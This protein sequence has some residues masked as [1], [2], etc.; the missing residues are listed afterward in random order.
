MWGGRND[1]RCW[2]A[3]QNRCALS[4]HVGPLDPQCRPA[5]SRRPAVTTH[6]ASYR[7]QCTDERVQ[8]YTLYTLS[9]ITSLT[10]RRVECTAIRLLRYALWWGARSGASQRCS[11]HSKRARNACGANVQRPWTPTRASKLQPPTTNAY[12]CAPKLPPSP[13]SAKT[14]AQ[15]LYVI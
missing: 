4:P 8:N 1:G 3:H 6:S 2:A 13:N 15:N 10:S 11:A 5:A 9:Y 7:L 14:R 12:P